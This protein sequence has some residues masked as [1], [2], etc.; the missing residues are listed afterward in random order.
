MKTTEITV[1]KREYI[2]MCLQSCRNDGAND[3]IYIDLDDGAVLVGWVDLGPNCVNLGNADVSNYCDDVESEEAAEQVLDCMDLNGDWN[4]LA[5]RAENNSTDDGT[6][7]TL[8]W[9][10]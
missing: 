10:D 9:V 3:W 2:D 5:A 4:I 6:P 8:N 1:S 7:V